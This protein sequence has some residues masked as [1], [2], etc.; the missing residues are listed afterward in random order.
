MKKPL[1]EDER[2]ALSHKMRMLG[3]KGG[4]TNKAKGKEYFQYVRSHR[5]AK[6]ET[7]SKD[8]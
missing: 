7:S 6:N 5:K 8:Q 1:T 2:I 4:A 3:R